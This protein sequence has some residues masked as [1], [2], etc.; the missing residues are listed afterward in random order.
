[1]AEPEAVTLQETARAS[2]EAK[3]QTVM[4][5]ERVNGDRG[6]TLAHTH[7]QK[8]DESVGVSS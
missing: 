1:M 3:I 6:H 4:S 5:R 7:T 8:G 2:Y